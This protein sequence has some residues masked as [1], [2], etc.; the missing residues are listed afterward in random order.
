MEIKQEEKDSKG[1]FYI[2]VDGKE[3]G[4]MTYSKA[5]DNKFI[6]DHTEV[7]EKYKGQSLGLKLVEAAVAYARSNNLK[8]MPLCPFAKKMFERHTEFNDVLW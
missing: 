2:L 7:D 8:I 4:E 3:A 1:R 6:I 5:G